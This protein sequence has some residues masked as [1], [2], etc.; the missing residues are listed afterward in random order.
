MN[1]KTTSRINTKQKKIS[2]GN[3]APTRFEGFDGELTVRHILGQGIFLFY[4]WGGKWYSSRFSQYT[5]S[6]HERNE[7]VYL[8]KGRKPKSI[9]EITM[10]NVNKIKINKA[11]TP[12]NQR[13]PLKP[14]RNNITPPTNQTI[15]GKSKLKF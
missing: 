14:N 1:K 15:I 3:T 5:R 11:I 4:K 2:T 8:P 7:P 9:G 12:N 13:M 10:D 6:T